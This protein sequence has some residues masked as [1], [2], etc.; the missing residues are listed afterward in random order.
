VSTGFDALLE[1]SR[2]CNK[3]FERASENGDHET[4]RRIGRITRNLVVIGREILRLEGNG[5]EK[6]VD[7]KITRLLDL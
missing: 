2:Q 6:A 1:V 7:E 4:V 3:L 5:D